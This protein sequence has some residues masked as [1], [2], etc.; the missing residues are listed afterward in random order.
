VIA[1]TPVSDDVIQRDEATTPVEILSDEPVTGV[2][3][4]HRARQEGEDDDDD[5]DATTVRPVASTR[6]PI[7]A[8][9]RNES[10]VLTEFN[11]IAQPVDVVQSAAVVPVEAVT[12]AQEQ[13]AEDSDSENEIS[14]DEIART[15]YKPSSSF[16]TEYKYTVDNFGSNVV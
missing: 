9:L 1:T 2:S 7:P 6:P 16:Q 10:T 12:Q 4:T 13:D 8:P 15:T 3:V 5:D 14:Q 11:F